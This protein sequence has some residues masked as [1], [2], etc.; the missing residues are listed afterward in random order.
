MNELTLQDLFSW[1]LRLDGAEISMIYDEIKIKRYNLLIGSI[2]N[3]HQLDWVICF[4]ISHFLTPQDIRFLLFTT[5]TERKNN[6]FVD[7][8]PESLITIIKDFL[9]EREVTGE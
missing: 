9:K 6:V 1:I 3:A 2:S 5:E 4:I 7:L 8:S